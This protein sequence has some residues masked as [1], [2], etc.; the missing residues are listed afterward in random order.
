M[1][2]NRPRDT[3]DVDPRIVPEHLRDEVARISP[4]V[5]AKLRRSLRNTPSMSRVVGGRVVVLDPSKDDDAEE[6]ALIWLKNDEAARRIVDRQ[7]D[8]ERQADDARRYT[9]GCC[10][11]VRPGITGRR[12]TARRLIDGT[13]AHVC[14]DCADVLDRLVVDRLAAEPLANGRTRLAAARDLL[15]RSTR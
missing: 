7:Q 2:K 15:E 3:S 10:S 13:K 9:C 1:L 11:L 8:A 12:T 14:G 4:D 6:T 5:E